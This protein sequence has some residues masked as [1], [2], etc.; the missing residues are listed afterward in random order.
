MVFRVIIWDS[1]CCTLTVFLRCYF[2]SEKSVDGESG[3]GYSSIIDRVLVIKKKTIGSVRGDV[4]EAYEIKY[5][6]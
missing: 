4:S 2:S 1:S 6:Y 3:R 5:I